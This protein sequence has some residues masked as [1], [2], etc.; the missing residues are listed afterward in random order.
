[1]VVRASATA[2]LFSS[3]LMVAIWSCSAFCISGLIICMALVAIASPEGI[4]GVVFSTASVTS[5]A[6]ASAASSSAAAGAVTVSSTGAS[7]G[8]T[9]AGAS[10]VAGALVSASAFWSLHA[11]SASREATAMGKTM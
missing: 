9:S 1:A 6:I 3:S 11:A 5:S 8:A 2:A 4:S 10:V 7:T